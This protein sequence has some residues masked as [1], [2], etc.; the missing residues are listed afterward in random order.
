MVSHAMLNTWLGKSMSDVCLNGYDNPAHNHCAHFVAHAMNLNFGYTCRDHV[1][2]S[3]PAA[4]LR[5]HEIFAH[6]SH[7]HEIL[8]TGPSLSGLV[9]VS[10]SRNFVTGG[11]RT[12]LR[13]VP[14]KHIGIIHGAMVWH[15]SNGRDQVIKQVMSQFL[16]HYPGQHNS[17][18]FGS[19]PAGAR[20][21]W[22]GQ[23]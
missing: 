9:F 15:Y 22:F 17:L 8:Q 13:N 3:H 19:L 6:C 10:A 12:T 18:W 7:T 20:P 1:G 23:C 11:G 4:N 16:A 5:V 21:I 14:K 2:G